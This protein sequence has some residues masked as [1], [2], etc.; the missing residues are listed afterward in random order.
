LGSFSTLKA[1]PRKTPR[2]HRLAAKAVDV[3]ADDLAILRD[4]SPIGIGMDLD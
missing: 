2:E 4:D 1:L 3:L